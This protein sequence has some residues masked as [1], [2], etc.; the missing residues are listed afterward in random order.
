MTT[1]KFSF[2]TLVDVNIILSQ[3]S[4]KM[5]TTE[6]TVK[7][8]HQSQ[9]SSRKQR[10]Y[11]Y[12]ETLELQDLAFIIKRESGDYDSS[13]I[14]RLNL[15]RIKQLHFLTST[16]HLNVFEWNALV[17]LDLSY[18][19]LTQLEGLNS[20]SLTQ[21]QHL[22][23]SFN[24]IQYISNDFLDPDNNSLISLRLE[25]NGKLRD[26][27][28][29]R[30]L[31]NVVSNQFTRLS[32][33]RCG[34]QG[35]DACPLCNDETYHDLIFDSFPHLE[36]LDEGSVEVLNAYLNMILE[37]KSEFK[38]NSHHQYEYEEEGAKVDTFQLESMRNC[39]DEDEDNLLYDHDHTSS[40]MDIINTLH[41]LEE[42][43]EVIKEKARESIHEVQRL[44][45]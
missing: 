8:T 27:E 35:Q 37:C 43:V 31:S 24:H 3:S 32:F 10:S 22:D 44:L 14:Q 19:K 30:N 4:L 6:V 21:L 45:K 29:I 7:D 33:Q 12:K 20:N 11:T 16:K 9:S 36:L 40:S 15:S 5:F 13:T 17:F 18:N 26:V 39:R 23:L 25:G 2:K 38:S 28:C 1:L 42:K 41:M 34:G